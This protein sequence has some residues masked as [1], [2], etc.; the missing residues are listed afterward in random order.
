MGSRQPPRLVHRP[1]SCGDATYRSLIQA[2]RG[3]SLPIWG[4][5]QV[6]QDTLHCMTQ[7]L[8]SEDVAFW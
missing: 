6:M 2:L 7:P 1:R 8:H 4:K 3:A 5:R